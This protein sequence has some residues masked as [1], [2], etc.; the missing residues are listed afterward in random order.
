MDDSKGKLLIVGAVV[1]IALALFFVFR[2]ATGPNQ[3]ISDPNAVP[4]KGA[5][6]FDT[7]RAGAV[8]PGMSPNSQQP[9][10]PSRADRM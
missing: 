7:D 10:M 4:P 1:V 5:G 2:S 9:Q 3:T 6:R 8:K